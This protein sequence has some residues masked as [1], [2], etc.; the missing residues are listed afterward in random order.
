MS[1][2][3]KNNNKIKKDKKSSRLRLETNQKK[4]QKKICFRW[5]VARRVKTMK[6]QVQL[7]LRKDR[8][9]LLIKMLKWM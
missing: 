1:S 6:K 7:C 3:T 4:N 9:L 5:K 2:K 8:L